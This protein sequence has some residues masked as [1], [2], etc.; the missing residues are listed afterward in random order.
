ME[1]TQIV[2]L[3]FDRNELAI[4]EAEQ[5]YGAH[6]FRLANR[7]LNN[8][9][10]AEETVSDTLLHTWNA[11][12]PE[13]PIALRAF[14]EK[15]TRNLALSRWRRR[16]AEKRG[17]GE[18]ELVLEELADCIP[19]GERPEQKLDEKELVKTIRN[20]LDT[21]P[22]REQ[23]IFLLR[24]FYVEESDKIAVRYGMKRGNVLWILSR[25]RMKLKTYLTQEG[26]DI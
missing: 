26:Y 25:T 3:F 15:I 11:V 13:R 19:G 12:P 20:F 7:I 10:D 23:D 21:L 8:R 22:R 17:G 1:D 2:E 9:E 18:L 4:R 16:S 5:K 14:L 6:C 24:Y